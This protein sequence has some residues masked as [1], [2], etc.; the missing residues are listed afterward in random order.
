MDI[1]LPSQLLDFNGK[2]ALVTGG[3]SGIGAEIARRFAQAG[4]D[5]AVC[6]LRPAKAVCDW[7]ESFGRRAMAIGADVCD[8]LQIKSV[9]EEI[10]QK[11][12][13]VDVLVN[14]AGIYPMA[15]LLSMTPEEW[16]RT[17]DIDL[18]AVFLCTQAAARS[19]I[20]AGKGGAIVNIAST[21]AVNPSAG[22]SHYAAAKAGVILFSKTAALELG[23]HQIRVNTVSPGLIN[24]PSLAADWPD[25]LERYQKR[26]PL[27][28]VGEPDDIADACLFLASDTARWISG[29]HLVV[30]G[31]ILTCPTY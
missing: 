21:E 27:G 3:G 20:K 24:R 19:M 31:G 26:V 13:A 30:D 29:A 16:D 14:N 9:F 2:V 18:K 11:W 8:P 17:L 25:G 1:K 28:R 10:E 6:D 23:A 22:H 4:A 7:I 12:S 15:D 5:V